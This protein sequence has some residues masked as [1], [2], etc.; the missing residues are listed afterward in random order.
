MTQM[1]KE[2]FVFQFLRN[3]PLDSL[4]RALP[5]EPERLTRWIA[6]KEEI[7]GFRLKKAL[8]LFGS[9]LDTFNYLC[10]L[11]VLNT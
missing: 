1:E 9:D 6:G 5:V 4:C 10:S 11:D 3:L 7:D 8:R 2:G